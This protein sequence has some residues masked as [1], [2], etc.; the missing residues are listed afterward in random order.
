MS[1]FR[2]VAYLLVSMD[3]CRGVFVVIAILLLIVTKD[4]ME[5]KSQANIDRPLSKWA[6]Q[7]FF[8]Y[9]LRED[10]VVANL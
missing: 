9:V 2:S 7:T 4:V 3:R 6:V 10:I 5:V 8:M 1:V